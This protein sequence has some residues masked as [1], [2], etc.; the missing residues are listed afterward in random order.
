MAQ[1][2]IN[3]ATSRPR[4]GRSKAKLVCVAPAARLDAWTAEFRE[5]CAAF[6]ALDGRERDDE[7]LR[8]LARTLIGAG[9]IYSVTWG[10]QAGRMDL[11]M[12]LLSSETEDAGGVYVMTDEFGGNEP[13]LE[14]SGTQSSAPTTMRSRSLLWSPSQTTSF[15]RR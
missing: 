3:R 8:E 10:P 13:L 12:D 1:A 7:E 9:C 5:P 6:I 2:T 14:G 11:I 4:V 15:W